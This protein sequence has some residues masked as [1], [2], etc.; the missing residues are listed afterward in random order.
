MVTT[1][2]VV[3]LIG[4]GGIARMHA[5]GW[6]ELG[7]KGQVYSPSSA[8]RFVTEHGGMIAACTLDEALEGVDFVDICTPT[9]THAQIISHAVKA[10]LDVLCEKPITRTAGRAREM[11]DAVVGRGLKFMPAHVVRWFND[12]DAAHTSIDAGDLGTI[13]T[14]SYSRTGPSPQPRW[15]HKL[16]RSGGMV[17]DLMV[18][19]FDQALWNAG[20]VVKVSGHE[21]PAALDGSQTARV[22]LIHQGGATSHIS[23]TWGPPGCQFHTTFTVTGTEGVLDHDS[24]EHRQGRLDEREARTRSSR[25]PQIVST[26]P[27]HLML[28][29]FL[30]WQQGGPQPRIKPHDGVVAVEVAQAALL[31]VQSGQTIEL[32]PHT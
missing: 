22:Q 7:V 11:V 21:L 32:E 1:T 18:H 23:G 12:Y 2:P 8:T 5:V 4:A 16:E 3:A 29:D 19:D 28:A 30:S 20:P 31:A 10:G 27:Y 15:F 17:M 14:L 6:A 13:D 26:S 9:D 24:L 25:H